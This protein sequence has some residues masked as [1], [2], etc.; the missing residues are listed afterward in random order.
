MTPASSRVVV[1]FASAA[2]ISGSASAT[3]HVLALRLE[4]FWSLFRR[5]RFYTLS[6]YI[7]GVKDGLFGPE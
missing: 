5:M 4:F 6:F 7:C 2:E 1:Y 3:L